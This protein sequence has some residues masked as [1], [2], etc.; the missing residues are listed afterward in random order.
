MY[1]M[2][3][4]VTTFLR[5]ERLLLDPAQGKVIRTYAEMTMPAGNTDDTDVR[6]QYTLGGGVSDDTLVWD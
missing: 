4:E 5:V 1:C 3:L 6:H 2:V